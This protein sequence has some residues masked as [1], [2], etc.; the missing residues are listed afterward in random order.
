VTRPSGIPSTIPPGLRLALAV[1]ILAAVWLVVLPSIGRHPAVA[2]HVRL[3]EACD[4]NPSA[5]VYTELE[6]LPLRPAWIEQHLVLWPTG[7]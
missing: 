4:A 6:R 2:R 1:A 5:M 3:M 7:N